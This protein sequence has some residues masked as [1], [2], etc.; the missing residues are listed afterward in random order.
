MSLFKSKRNIQLG[1]EQIGSVPSSQRLI[2]GSSSKW[3]IPCCNS[4]MLGRSRAIQLPEDSD[5]E[6][7]EYNQPDFSANNQSFIGHLPV[8]NTPNVFLQNQTDNTTRI[9]SHNPFARASCDDS[10]QKNKQNDAVIANNN[11]DQISVIGERFESEV[12][13]QII[14]RL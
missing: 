8:E 13:T 3:S 14:I 5:L 10:S 7:D 6:D 9:L 2:S 4:L 12:T 11:Q 1:E